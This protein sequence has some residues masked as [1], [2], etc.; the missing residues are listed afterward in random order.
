MAE[1]YAG[2]VIG[3]VVVP[4]MKARRLAE[5]TPVLVVPQPDW[6]HH[7]LTLSQAAEQFDTSPRAIRR[8]VQSGKVRVCAENRK[9]VNAG[10]VED[11][12]DQWELFSL[13]M[14]NATKDESP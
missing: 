2:V 6:E 12:V 14:E 11:A 8:W 7:W 5:G 10:D 3:G 1:A 4:T 13:T 9:L